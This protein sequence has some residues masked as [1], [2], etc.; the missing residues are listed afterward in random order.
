MDEGVKVIVF[1]HVRVAGNFGAMA[2]DP[3]MPL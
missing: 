2:V 1:N 3:I